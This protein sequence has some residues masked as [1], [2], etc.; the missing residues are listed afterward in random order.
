MRSGD[1]GLP[2]P[3]DGCSAWLQH[4]APMRDAVVAPSA[5]LCREKWNAKIGAA[6][7]RPDSIGAVAR[8]V[9][10]IDGK[11]VASPDHIRARFDRAVIADIGPGT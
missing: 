10:P 5:N 1:L 9:G 2:S 7:F 8:H 3:D 4:P 11:L 6:E